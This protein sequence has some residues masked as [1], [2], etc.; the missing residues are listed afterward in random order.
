VP[1]VWASSSSIYG[2]AVAYPTPE[3]VL[4]KPISPYGITKL[5]CEHLQEAYTRGFGLRAV[6]LRYFS[7]YGPRQRPDMA[8]A[9]ML[10]SLIR[11]EEF[12]IYGDGLQS[13][14][15]TYVSDVVDATILAL[16][17]APGVYNVGGGEEVNLRDVATTLEELTGRRARLAYVPERTGDMRRSKADI[18]RIEHELGWCPS[19]LL[20]EGLMR[21]WEWTTARSAAR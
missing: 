2:D 18:S 4:P 8:F 1:V 19:T 3:G 5:A 17:A 20:S 15:F 14:S 9:R 10:D 11:D 12:E 6:A 21:Q 7:V 13:R 16:D